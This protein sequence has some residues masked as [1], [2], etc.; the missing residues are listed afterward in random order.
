MVALLNRALKDPLSLFFRVAVDPVALGIP[1]YFEI[2]PP[3]DA[4]DLS[5]IKSKLEKSVYSTARQVDDEVDL[6]LENARVFNG[7]G[8]AVTEA[9]NMFAAWWKQQRLKMDV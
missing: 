2:I 7:E 4:R 5:L 1:Q 3:E 8:D 6:M 9:A